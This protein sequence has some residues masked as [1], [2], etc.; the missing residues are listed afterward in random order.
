MNCF[1]IIIPAHNEEK[2]ITNTLKYASSL[3]YPKDKFEIIV[4]ENGSNDK[5]L[6]LARSFSKKNVR[7]FSIKERGVSRARNFGATKARFEWLIFLDADTLLKRDFLN[8][9][10]GFLSRKSKEHIIGTTELVPSNRA[11]S[12]RLWFIYHN[13]VHR[14]FG[15]SSTPQIVKR[16]L[17]N[18][19]KYD[20]MLNFAEDLKLT[21]EI[22]KYGKLF[23]MPTKSVIN[24]TRRTE[25]VGNFR[26][27]IKWTGQSFMP[28]SVKVKKDY[29][30]IR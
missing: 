27:I 19:V 9:L 16:N 20:E 14:V 5:T 29:E 3:R 10:N 11:M 21:K 8:E 24:S 22:T 2:Y 6:K 25:K 12:H 7:V 28:Y 13:F 23:Y 26:Q 30:V 1:S 15:V 18:K 17:F 4:V